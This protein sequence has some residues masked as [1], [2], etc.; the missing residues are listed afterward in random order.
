MGAKLVSVAKL[1]ESFGVVAMRVE[2][3]GGL[4]VF[5][6]GAAACVS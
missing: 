2:G 1:V 3:F 4:S 5:S 6:R